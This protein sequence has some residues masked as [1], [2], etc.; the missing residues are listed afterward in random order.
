MDARL[1]PVASFGLRLLH[2][3]PQQG[4]SH[5]ARFEGP[6]TKLACMLIADTGMPSCAIDPFEVPV[7]AYSLSM[8]APSNCM[9]ADCMYVCMWIPE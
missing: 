9:Y 1:P 4:E 2:S 8:W 5:T 6:G 7:I 3:R